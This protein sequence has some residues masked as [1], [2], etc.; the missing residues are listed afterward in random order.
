MNYTIIEHDR[1]IDNDFNVIYVK[2][3]TGEILMIKT[4]LSETIESIKKKIRDIKKCSTEPAR[5]LF[6]GKHLLDQYTLNDYHVQAGAILHSVYP[7]CGGMQIF[8]KYGWSPAIT[9]EVNPRDTIEHVK[10][11]LQDE[12]GI[13][14]DQQRLVCKGEELESSRT[15]S[16]YKIEKESTM[17]LVIR[18]SEGMLIFFKTLT[19]TVFIYELEPSDTVAYI[20]AK[21]EHDISIALRQQKLI[22]AG[23]TLHNDQTLSYYNIQKG[24]TICFVIG[25]AGCVSFHVKLPSG[26]NIELMMSPGFTTIE[27]VK[28]I[29]ERQEGIPLYQQRLVFQGKLLENRRIVSD[30]DIDF[31]NTVF[32]FHLDSGSMQIFVETPTVKTLTL[33]ADPSDTIKS[34][35]R[36]IT[37]IQHIRAEDQKLVF[38]GKQLD[39]DK[40]LLDYRIKHKSKLH[41]FIPDE[42]QIYVKRQIGKIITLTVRPSD[43][44]EDVKKKI[45]IAGHKKHLIFANIELEDDRTLSDYNIG[46]EST[47]EL[48]IPEIIQVYVK[49]LTGEIITLVVRSSDTIKNV[50]LKLSQRGHIPAN[51]QKLIFAGSELQDHRQLAEHNIRHNSTLELWLRD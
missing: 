33:Q 19:G 20:K 3:L 42:V 34:V 14:A 22:L 24:T 9:L 40:T 36:N 18:R 8:V 48:I 13:P 29:I 28:S 4:E 50:K 16:D 38:D 32:L 26:R 45:K 30:Y 11:K 41:L 46:H 49:K 23:K 37:D 15:L 7:L 21:I 1:S 10:T 47:L 43:F 6:A 39:D 2:M 27:E 17:L 35:K 12:E 44:I 31:D 25:G 5:L 51:E